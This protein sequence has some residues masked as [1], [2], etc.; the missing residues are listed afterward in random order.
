MVPEERIALARE[1]NPASLELARWV[2]LAPRVSSALIRRA[3]L[4]CLPATGPD[5]ESDLWFGPLTEYRERGSVILFADV[6]SRLRAELSADHDRLQRAHKLLDVLHSAPRAPLLTL[7]EELI[8][9]VMNPAARDNAKKRLCE[10]IKAIVEQDRRGLSRWALGLRERIP[11]LAMWKETNLL[12]AVAFSAL[13]G[14]PP[15][16]GRIGIELDDAEWTL[17][18]KN[19]DYA[20]I[21]LYYAGGYLHVREPPHAG[22]AIVDVPAG[23]IRVIDVTRDGISSVPTLSNRLQWSR[24][25]GHAWCQVEL[26]STLSMLDGVSVRLTNRRPDIDRLQPVVARFFVT[27]QA[28]EAAQSRSG[29]LA[30]DDLV[31]TADSVVA[32][33]PVGSDELTV[34]FPH[35]DNSAQ[36]ARLARPKK[37]NDGDTLVFVTLSQLPSGAAAAILGPPITKSQ[38]V[39]VPSAPSHAREV[40]TQWWRFELE[41]NST[42]GSTLRPLSLMETEALN[43]CAGSPAIDPRS[44]HVVGTCVVVDD[45]A[46]CKSLD[47]VRQVLRDRSTKP[48]SLGTAVRPLCFMIMPYGRKPTQ[49][50]P[51]HGPTEVDFNALWDLGY[52][53]AIRQLGYEPMRADQDTGALTMSQMLERLFFADLVLADMTIANGNV[54]YQLGIRHAARPKGC[55]LLAADWSRQLFDVAQMRTIRYPLPEGELTEAAAPAFQAAIMAAIPTLASGISPMHASIPGFPFQVDERTATS[56]K[57]QMTE[58]AAF[59]ASA[60]AARALPR[61]QRMKRA[62]ELVAIHGI[63]PMTPL[64]AIAL[65]RLLRD[66]ADTADDWATVLDFIG[67]LPK[68]LAKAAE[69]QEQL[70]F[71]LSN[72]G[73]NMEAITALEALIDLAGPT[74]ERLSL[75]GGRYKRE[76]RSASADDRPRYLNKS[77]ECYERGMDLDLNDYYCSSNLPRLYLQ[78]KRRGD[79]ARAAT[80]L[81]LVIAACERAMRRGTAD[82]WL[83]PT[84]LGAAFDAGDVDKIEEL[85][86]DIAVEGVTRWRLESILHDLVVSAGNVD[87]AEQ[88]ARLVAVVDR[89]R[90]A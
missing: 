11:E 7:E 51:G 43:E 18:R 77:I 17:L 52:V 3:R 8:W 80:V 88:R 58:V 10:I 62:E 32:G 89:F 12:H 79:D 40:P 41:P 67:K 27:V 54:Y 78:R 66:S 47:E 65:L 25:A 6:A 81:K 37:D 14:A 46:V 36:Y 90:P 21:G 50:E 48:E 39:V 84:L 9:G 76:M 33:R 83:R 56:M 60:R 86:D 71:A 26:P 75:L 31:V 35:L 15:P 13:Y 68:E 30:Q 82:E 42:G 63:P 64:V 45:R 49:A 29:W 70:A 87:D 38:V 20:R 69:T 59:Q 2:S 23:D 22:D 72:A 5:A 44:G 74:P 73:R 53:P 24:N 34:R 61:S 85:A 16:K 1:N 28:V 57:D 4:Q 19:I 55:V